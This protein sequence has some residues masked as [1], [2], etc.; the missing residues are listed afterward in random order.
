MKPIVK[1]YEDIQTIILNS[2]FQQ[3]KIIWFLPSWNSNFHVGLLLL[4]I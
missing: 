4:H 1:I 2:R 3:N